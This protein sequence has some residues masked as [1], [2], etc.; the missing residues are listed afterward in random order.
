[1]SGRA[2]DAVYVCLASCMVLFYFCQQVCVIIQWTL[3]KTERTLQYLMF[4]HV[5]LSLTLFLPPNFL[6]CVFHFLL[7]KF[8]ILGVL[9]RYRKVNTI[10]VQLNEFSQTEHTHVAK[11]WIQ[12]IITLPVLPVLS[13][14]FTHF[15]VTSLDV[16]ISSS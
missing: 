6:F 5:L 15:S 9:Y 2:G 7:L 1:M 3:G 13:N 10:N 11:D 8:F 14:A 12:Q 16:Y 4:T